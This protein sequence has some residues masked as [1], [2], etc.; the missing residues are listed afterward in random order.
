VICCSSDARGRPN[1][2]RAS[3]RVRCFSS[4]SAVQAASPTA[5]L[6]QCTIAHQDPPATL[7]ISTPLPLEADTR[8]GAILGTYTSNELFALFVRFPLDNSAFSGHNGSILE[9]LWSWTMPT[10]T[11]KNVPPELYER[12]KR[13]AKA[14]RRSI[15]SEIIVCIERALYSRKIDAEVIL[16]RARKLRENTVD[17]PITDEEFTQAKATGRP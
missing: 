4:V 16:P 11:L 14:N 13:S 9:P 6:P 1:A 7:A 12:L 5:P 17:Y 8:L 10:I 15:N 2:L 3:Q